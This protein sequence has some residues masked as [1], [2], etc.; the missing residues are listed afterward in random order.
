MTSTTLLDGLRDPHNATRWQ[1]YVGRYRPLLLRFVEGH[2]VTGE[3]AEDVVQNALLEFARAYRDGRYQ[4]ERGRLSSWLF[5]ILHR[6]LLKFRERAG[7][8]PSLHVD[9][10]PGGDLFEPTAPPEL[11]AAWEEE[12]E[13]AVLSQCLEEIRGEVA[14]RTYRAFVGFALEGRPAAEVG[15]ELGLSENAVFSAKRRILR[16]IRE[17]LPV[18]RDAWTA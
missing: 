5:G 12:W 8:Q 3:D 2:G 10:E 13:Q 1:Q 14:P 7:R 4:R 11:V 15:R 18:L 16:R 6:Q 9:L 17:L